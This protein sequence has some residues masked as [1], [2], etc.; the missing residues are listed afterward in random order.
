[1]RPGRL[2][3][4]LLL[5]LAFS[6]AS[7]AGED[8]CPGRF[9][10]LG[11]RVL[12]TAREA[13]RALS[14]ATRTYVSEVRR[15]PKRLV[16]APRD[17]QTPRKLIDLLIEVPFNPY[18]TLLNRPTK[19]SLPA[20]MALWSLLVDVALPGASEAVED[21][22][23][24]H[25]LSVKGELPG[26]DYLWS[27][28]Q[29]GALTPMEGAEAIETHRS[30]LRE[31]EAA[32]AGSLLLPRAEAFR[33]EA[34]I[35]EAPLRR[36][37]AH[38]RKVHEQGLKGKEAF[39]TLRQAIE[40][41][42][43]F[44]AF[45]EP[46]REMLATYPWPLAR[47]EGLSDVAL[48]LRIMR[49]KGDTPLARI[50]ELLNSGLPLGSAYRMASEAGREKTFEKKIDSARNVLPPARLSSADRPD[51]P[52]YSGKFEFDRFGDGKRL[53]LS[54]ELDRWRLILSDPRLAEVR[55]AWTKGE[56][57]DL[58][59]LRATEGWMRGL[60]ELQALKGAA[61]ALALDD[62][63]IVRI[64]GLENPKELN[65]LLAEAR[66]RVDRA[67]LASELDDRAALTCYRQ[68][69]GVEVEFHAEQSRWVGQGLSGA[70]FERKLEGAL[71][72]YL[73]ARKTLVERC[74]GKDGAAGR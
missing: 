56:L 3:F 28:V 33:H 5:L 18:A 49:A 70:A 36:L 27:L 44:G 60:D 35:P 65:P 64:F 6:D 34:G 43:A 61:G 17:N 19:L 23:L 12:A 53:R 54:S 16:F 73:K 46:V 21:R 11:R 52:E 41:D 32:E 48:G 68:A 8:P 15:S 62:A 13:G 57:G 69:A 58:E 63:A 74:G 51:I 37:D 42:P 14:E 38:A 55:S 47:I 50:H 26:G 25:T 7:F 59:A 22:I 1:M 30:K 20:S 31:W 39:L 4:T 9:E 45:P 72:G 29:S 10:L 24:L 2:F 66:V 67:V 71:S 40:D